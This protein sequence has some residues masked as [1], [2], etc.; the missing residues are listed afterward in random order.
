MNGRLDMGLYIGAV[1]S[2]TLQGD[3]LQ[4]FTL[5][6]RSRSIH[7]TPWMVFDLLMETRAPRGKLTEHEKNILTPFRKLTPH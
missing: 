6:P 3:Q 5:V 7:L 4:G 1:G 2:H